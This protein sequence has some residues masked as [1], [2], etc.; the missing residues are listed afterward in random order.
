MR[1]IG[2]IHADFFTYQIM[3]HEVEESVQVGDFGIGFKSDYWHE[4]V[5]HF[6]REH[7]GHR[8]I[9][10]NHDNPELCKSMTGWITDGHYENGMMFIGGAFSIDKHMRTPGVDWWE[11]EELSFS[12]LNSI[13]DEYERKKPKVVLTHDCPYEAAHELFFRSGRL[14]PLS[15]N[16]SRTAMALQSMFEIH[17][18]DFWFFG[19]WHMTVSQ[20]IGNTHFQ[21]I[22]INDYI[23]LDMDTMELKY[24]DP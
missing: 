8:F 14:T 18:P 22:G 3:L 5:N 9:R 2:D 7:S 4:T 23:D 10:G 11:D 12:D 19:H 6:H 24:T 21:C 1:I 15:D 20:K 16:N 17:Q 13:I